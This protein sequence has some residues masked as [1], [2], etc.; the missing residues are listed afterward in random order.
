MKA[1]WPVAMGIKHISVN[2]STTDG[3]NMFSQAIPPAFSKYIIEQFLF[4]EARK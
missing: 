4:P 1:A 2:A 3:H